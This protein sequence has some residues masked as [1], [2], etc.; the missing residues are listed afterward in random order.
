[1]AAVRVLERGA[2]QSRT[3]PAQ[4]EESRLPGEA[5]G[6]RGSLTWVE[7]GVRRDNAMS[8]LL[9]D[10]AGQF[11]GNLR[12]SRAIHGSTQSLAGS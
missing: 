10:D 5:G 9:G 3:A 11:G 12:Q 7:V 8:S 6:S 1:M 4:K 2:A